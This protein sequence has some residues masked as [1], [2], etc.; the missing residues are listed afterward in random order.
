MSTE[1]IVLVHGLWMNS[2][3][4][5]LLAR[6]M[7][8]Y[9]YKTASFSYNSLQKTPRQNAEDLAEFI[10]RLDG[11][12][13]HFICHSL[14]GIVVRHLFYSFPAQRPGRVVTLGTP[15]K[16]GFCAQK[17]Y[18]YL[19]GRIILGKSIIEGL[20]GD[21][22]PWSTTHDLGSI[23]GTLGWGLGRLLL[24]L[25]APNDGVVGVDETRF[26]GMKDHICVKTSHI[27][28]LLSSTVASHCREFFQNGT[29]SPL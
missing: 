12:V 16:P 25:P 21:I 9:G 14:G 10:S 2:A 3:E 15:H 4:M 5:V 19:P 13:V 8:K 7:R 26:D 1:T 28:L 23:A 11:P 27:G 6:R 20:L 18:R 24:R 29:F 22:P 17:L